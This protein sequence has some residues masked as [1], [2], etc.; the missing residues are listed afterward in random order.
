MCAY[1][2]DD[3]AESSLIVRIKFVGALDR[4]GLSVVC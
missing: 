2:G 3:P 1:S 4:R